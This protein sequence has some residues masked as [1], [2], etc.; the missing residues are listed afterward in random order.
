MSN[1]QN[2]TDETTSSCSSGWQSALELFLNDLIQRGSAEKTRRAY[3]SDCTQLAAWATGL[4]VEPA[5]LNFQLIR[6]YLAQLSGSG[7]AAGTVARKLSAI[8]E[9]LAVLVNHGLIAHSPADLVT[10]PKLPSRLP[11]TLSPSDLTRLL[12]RIP[13]STPLEL[14]DRAVFETAYSSGLRAEELV[15]LNTDWL[16]F[17]HEEIRVEGKGSKTRIVPLGEHARVSLADYLERAR[18]ALA[19]GSKEPALFLSKRGRRLSTSDIRRRLTG[20]ARRVE[21]GTGISPHM[22]RHSFATHMLEG[23]ADLRSIQELLGH[24]SLSTTQLYTRIDAKRLKAI[25]ASSHP[26]A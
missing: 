15:S 13:A 5:K 9:L 11:R 18:P 16:D 24:A 4:G 21:L 1:G 12:D 17:D 7:L 19:A 3:L 8:R 6:R 14:R 23:G 10:R 22:F 26:R 2:S 20:W 25:Y